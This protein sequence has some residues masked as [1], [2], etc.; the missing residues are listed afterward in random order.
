L[1]LR[2]LGL[3]WVAAVLGQGGT[4]LA[5]FWALGLSTLPAILIGSLLVRRAYA[6]AA[7]LPDPGIATILRSSLP[8]AVNGGLALLSLRVE[9]LVVSFFRGAEEAGYFLAAL[10][11]VQ[12]LNSTIPTSISAG[13]MPS[14][15][16]EALAAGTVDAVRRR[17]A[18][19]VALAAAP[20]CLG[21]ALVAPA[22]TEKLY[23]PAY[24]PSAPTLTVLALSLVP[25]FVNGFIT[26]ALIAA[27]RASL[28]PRLTAL[29]VVLAALFA[30]VLVPAA[31]GPGAALGFAASE[32]V[33]VAL[34]ARDARAAGFPVRIA[35]PVLLAFAVS[36]PMAAAVLPLRHDLLPAL[37]VG[38]L[39]FG[40]TL[41][42]LARSRRVRGELGYS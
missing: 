33:L 35:R 30:A 13:A 5:C 27:E 15:T 7:P 40:A 18:S 3:G 2:L 14:L 37:A 34:G 39:T 36:V 38:V 41:A 11:V 16:R 21:L 9:L 26:H 10:Q 31:G 32:C 22:L 1:V 17:T 19:T 24:A 28:L 23:G 8:L 12:V 4:A 6:A 29:R 25:L 42:L 20:A